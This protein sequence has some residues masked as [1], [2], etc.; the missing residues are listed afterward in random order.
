MGIDM[1]NTSA[2]R[3]LE[4][5]VLSDSELL[6]RL[7][8]TVDRD[9]AK[10]YVSTYHFEMRVGEQVAGGIRFR[11]ENDF[12]VESYAGNVGYNVAPEFR[13]RHFAERACRL[14]IPLAR[15][16]GFSCLWITC[17]PENLASR[18]TCERL[19]AQLIEVVALP[20][21]SDMYL[22]GERYK[23]RYRL[24]LEAAI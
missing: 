10:Q 16:H 6:L 11:A 14:L 3:F 5:G 9:D 17:D 15:A 21:D 12:D 7:V 13:G 23:C 4:V 8:K 22:D 20:A 18:R 19:G 2:F 1:D 24:D